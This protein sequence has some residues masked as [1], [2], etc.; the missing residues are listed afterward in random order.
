MPF[1]ANWRVFFFPGV[2]LNCSHL[3]VP[4]AFLC[5]KDVKVDQKNQL[6]VAEGFLFVFGWEEAKRYVWGQSLSHWWDGSPSGFNLPVFAIKS[7]IKHGSF[8]LI[9]GPYD[10][11]VIA[12][13][14]YLLQ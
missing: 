10:L 3:W 4:G 14:K 2:E 9:E 8:C 5:W 1:Q 12:V 11:V 13:T 6:L 7:V